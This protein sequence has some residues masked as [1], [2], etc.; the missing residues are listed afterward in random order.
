LRRLT[1][2]EGGEWLPVWTPD[3]ERVAFDSTRQGIIQGSMYL[4]SVDG[5]EPPERLVEETNWPCPH[6]FS[7]DGKLLAFRMISTET[8]YDIWMLPMDGKKKPWVYLQTKA[9]ETWPKFS[10]DGKWIVYQSSES[11]QIE[12]YVRSSQPSIK[13]HQQ[14][15]N[16]GGQM[17]LWSPDGREVYYMKENKIMGVAFQGEPSLKVGKPRTVVEGTF[18]FVS[19][20]DYLGGYDISPDGRRFL[21]VTGG[22]P[23]TMIVVLNWFEELRRKAPSGK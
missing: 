22:E 14:V 2:E 19:G 16:D 7:P 10:P 11:G 23:K 5:D 12:V 8:S 20:H 3:G 13:R 18:L 4:K 9:L 15:S 17:P 6:S 1:D 21:A